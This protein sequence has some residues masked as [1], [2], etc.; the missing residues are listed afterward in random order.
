V[1]T[2]PFFARLFVSSAKPLA[3]LVFL[4]GIGFCVIQYFRASLAVSSAEYQ[5]SASLQQSIG[6]LQ[7]AFVSAERIVGSFNGDKGSAAGFAFPSPIRSN[8]DFSRF[9]AQLSLADQRRQQ[10]KQ[11][12]VDRFEN[13][14]KGIEEKLRVFA[15]GLRKGQ[16]A[17]TPVE[18]VA[19][20]A[21]SSSVVP[22]PDSLFSSRLKGSDAGERMAN[23]NERKDFLKA[24]SAKAE[25]ADNR[26][27][28]AE[29]ADQ[30]GRLVQLLPEKLD[31]P[32]AESSLPAP[33]SAGDERAE[34]AN[35]LFLSERVAHQLG[36]LRGEVRQTLLTSWTL[37]DAFDQVNAQAATEREKC[38]VATNQQQAIWLSAW[39][40]ILAGWFLTILTSLLILVSASLVTI[41]YRM[42]EDGEVV[43]NGMRVIQGLRRPVSDPN[44]E[45]MRF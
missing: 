39:A 44:Q 23:L 24:L 7:D 25:N 10:L 19:S 38:R 43:A 29:A 36:Q 6:R 14:V 1:N 18:P 40:R 3:F 11:S 4:A 45:V 34:Q 8:D 15:A 37:D 17:T 35:S 33:A 12:I 31:A 32:A 13:P 41:V 16:P 27:K 30:L 9:G 21:P 42:A 2:R 28:L 22:R 26:A 5:P 20:P